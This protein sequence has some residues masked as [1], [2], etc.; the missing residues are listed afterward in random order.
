MNVLP[1]FDLSFSPKAFVYL[2]LCVFLFCGFSSTSKCLIRSF[3]HSENIGL[4]IFKSKYEKCLAVPVAKWVIPLI[5]DGSF[6]HF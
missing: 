3:D 6:Y 5:I 2:L 1:E 4:F